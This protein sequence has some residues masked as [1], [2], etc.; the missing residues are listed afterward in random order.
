MDNLRL[1][2]YEIHSQFGLET[3]TLGES[4]SRARERARQ[5]KLVF[6]TIINEE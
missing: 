2:G 1:A 5:A 4:I 6:S 3:D